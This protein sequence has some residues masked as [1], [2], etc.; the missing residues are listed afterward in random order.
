LLVGAEWG[1][2][3]SISGVRREGVVLKQ[4]EK[5]KEWEG[6]DIVYLV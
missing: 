2:S 5:I 3:L 6:E 1:R 4:T